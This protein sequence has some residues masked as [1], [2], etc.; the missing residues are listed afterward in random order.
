MRK[1]ALA[2]IGLMALT[3]SSSADQPKT[4]M[5][6]NSSATVAGGTNQVDKV[7]AHLLRAADHLEAAGLNSDASRIREEAGQ[8]AIPEGNLSRKEA[9]LECLQHEVDRLRELAGQVPGVIVDVMVVEV[10]HTKLGL[11]AGEFDKLVGFSAVT[12]AQN[13]EPVA[14]A[15]QA[16]GKVRSGGTTGIV[17]ANP[18]LLPLFRELRDRGA[19]SIETH[20]S[21]LVRSRRPG[22]ISS[23]GDFPMFVKGKAGRIRTLA[24]GA[25]VEIVADM[26]SNQR[27]RLQTA[28]SLRRLTGQRIVDA[29]GTVLPGISSRR[30]NTEVELQLGQTL[31]VGRMADD[32]RYDRNNT[33]RATIETIVFVT[34]RPVPSAG[35]ARL[36]PVGDGGATE[37]SSAAVE[38]VEFIPA[39]GAKLG[40]P[41]PVQKRRPSRN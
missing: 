10:D 28:V 1:M 4:I 34:P 36:L 23:G 24:I 16:A 39:D 15:D 26:L 19:I 21:L 2:S 3:L 25:E 5:P 7:V 29:E 13:R 9:E 14:D 18:A 11:K 17:D 31:A 40:P 38:P 33:D 32:G 41:M 12:E 22:S 35:E 27:V 6:A 20:Q 30:L 37:E 8:R